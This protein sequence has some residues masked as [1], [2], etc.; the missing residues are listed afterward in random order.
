MLGTKVLVVDDDLGICDI[1][2]VHFEAEG[3]QVFTANDGVEGD[4]KSVV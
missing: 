3:C 4:R 2:K 1:L